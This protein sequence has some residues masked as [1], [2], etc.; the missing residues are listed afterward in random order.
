MKGWKQDKRW[1]DRFL[2]EIKRNL[3]EH[4][5]GEPPVEEDQERNTDLIVLKMEAIRVGCRIRKHK[6]L[7]KYGDEFTIRAGRPS[8][9]KVELTKIVE[10]WGNYFLYGFCDEQEL[11]LAKWILC[12]LNVFRLWFNRKLKTDNGKVPGILKNNTD[13]PSFFLSFKT[14]WLPKEFIIAQSQNKA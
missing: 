5:I 14:A 2:P 7:K 9:I 11:K 13:N 12:D 6:Y 8:G 1:S 3:G 10:G 4:L